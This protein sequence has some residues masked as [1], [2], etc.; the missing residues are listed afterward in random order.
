MVS[1]YWT[2]SNMFMLGLFCHLTYIMYIYT[3]KENQ[4]FTEFEIND[5]TNSITNNGDIQAN[6]EKKQ[7]LCRM[8]KIN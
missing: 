2:H 7:R 4:I 3:Y 6:L 8:N 1:W 5:M